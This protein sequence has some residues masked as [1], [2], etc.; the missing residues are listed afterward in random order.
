MSAW[1]FS[2]AV[3]EVAPYVYAPFLIVAGGCV[4]HWLGRHVSARRVAVG[5]ALLSAFFL[6]SVLMTA[7]PAKGP[8]G[9][10]NANAA[11][12]V[13]LMGL[14]GLLGLHPRARALGWSALILG[15]LTV[16]AN[17]SAGA[18]IVALPVLLVSLYATR[19]APGLHRWPA[20][21]IGIGSLTAT[22]VGLVSLARSTEWSEFA[23]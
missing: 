14:G 15:L 13:Q 7:G 8:I 16:L 19:V 12:A 1:W 3:R 18:A 9:Y 4:G 11:V 20:A 2:S 5:T 23:L 22:T 10:A 6:V 17:R 21:L